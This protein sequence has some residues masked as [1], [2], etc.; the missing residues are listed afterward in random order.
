MLRCRPEPFCPYIGLG[1]NEAL[2]PKLS[3]IVFVTNLKVIKLGN[4]AT[5][6]NQYPLKS[7]KV[8]AGSKVFLL[9]D[10]NEFT[11]PDITGWSSSEIMSFCN[12]IGLDY[13]FSGYGVVK[14]FNLTAGELIDL[15]KTLEVTLETV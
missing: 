1:I 9:T 6:I 5:I 12:L 7:T 11:M 3:A 14:E 13:T 8:L 4:G 2:N 10:N 15:T